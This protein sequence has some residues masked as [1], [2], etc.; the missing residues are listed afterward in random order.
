MLPL[1]AM[2]ALPT[3]IVKL[4]SLF[5]KNERLSLL[6][7]GSLMVLAIVGM[8][9]FS[10][11]SLNGKAMNGYQLNELENTRQQLVEDGEIT[12]MLSLRA[13]AMDVIA[14]QTTYMIKPANEEISYVMP[15]NVVAKNDSEF[16][17]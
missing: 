5:H 12:D 17:Y 11:T 3:F 10:L 16:G 4:Q 13:R 6:S 8:G 7:I 9:L 1:S 14:S 2:K 15:V